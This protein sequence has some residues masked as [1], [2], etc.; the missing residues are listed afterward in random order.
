MC[1]TC[2]RTY[3]SWC[4]QILQAHFVTL[5]YGLVIENSHFAFQTLLL[6]IPQRAFYVGLGHMEVKSGKIK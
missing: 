3:G 1:L 5:F 6:Q 2:L 4:L